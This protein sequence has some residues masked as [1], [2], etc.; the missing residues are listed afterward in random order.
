MAT[1]K[2]PN[3]NSAVEDVEK[4]NPH[5]LFMGVQA[6]AVTMETGV[7]ILQKLEIE[8]PYDPA[9]TLLGIYFYTLSYPSTETHSHPCLLLLFHTS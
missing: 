2:K 3:G 1:V 4:G 8:L 6:A 5:A 9:V 7:E